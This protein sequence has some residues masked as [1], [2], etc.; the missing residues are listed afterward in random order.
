[1]AFEMLE[2]IVLGQINMFNTYANVSFIV[3]SYKLQY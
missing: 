3:I 1:M 2:E